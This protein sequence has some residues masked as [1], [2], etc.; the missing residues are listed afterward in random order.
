MRPRH[1]RGE[2]TAGVVLACLLSGA[3]CSGP[4]DLGPT[5]DDEPPSEPPTVAVDETPVPVLSS[6]WYS[7][8]D[9]SISTEQPEDPADASG[10][11]RVA[12]ADD[13]VDVHVVPTT[14]PAGL[15][16]RFF[17]AVDGTGVPASPQPAIRCADGDAP[18][19]WA[20]GDDLTVTVR[21]PEDARFM[22]V[23]LTYE[24]PLFPSAEPPTSSAAY[25]VFLD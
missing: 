21:P 15:D 13:S 5:S 16:V 2:R 12:V 11:P 18:C 10:L 20:D 23:T 3:A 22:T 14:R 25:G 1:P 19:E 9:G 6:E 4:L 17:L 7:V 8:R 24:V